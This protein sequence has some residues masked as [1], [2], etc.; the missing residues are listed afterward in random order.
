MGAVVEL[1]EDLAAWR[2]FAQRWDELARNVPFRSFAWLSTWWEHYGPE[3][4]RQNS[5]RLFVLVVR[6]TDGTPLGF[7]PWMLSSSLRA[8]RV[9]SMLGTGEV[10]SD[11]LSILAA[12]GYELQVADLLAQ[13]LCGPGEKRWDII[14][15]TG[16]DLEDRTAN[17]L[18][19]ALQCR[20]LST[21][22]RQGL[23]T[24]RLT[25]PNSWEDYLT[26]LSKSH[27]KKI[28]RLERSLLDPGQITV[29]Q[30]ER[31]DQLPAAYELFVELHQ[32]RW[33]SLSQPGCFSSPRFAGFLEAVTP[34]LLAAGQLRLLWLQHQG[35]PIAADYMLAG[36]DVLYS[37]QGGIEPECLDLQPGR[38]ELI[39]ALQGAIADGYRCYD[40]LR[41]NEPY[42]AYYGAEPRP[43][44]A[45]RIVSPRLSA[46]VRNHAW[47]VG[48]DA[49]LWIKQ[50]LLGRQS[51]GD[52][53]DS[54]QPV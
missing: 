20:S 43:T 37:Y 19:G 39:A 14:D 15:L 34:R 12:Q 40:F 26:Q 44:A 18:V 32:R 54:P 21:H 7:A 9:L 35:R 24:W 23:A 45:I 13:W 46:Q 25:L 30:V 48:E 50:K 11:Y 8:G 5:P 17:L 29:R 4:S 16:V 22:R 2:P 42:K 49:K 6:D 47:Q 28:R 38:L 1:V 33:R 31:A 36:N 41:G 53:L 3:D 51:D 10:Y 52:L 27:R